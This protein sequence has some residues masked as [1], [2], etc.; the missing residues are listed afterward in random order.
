[1]K[2]N[3]LVNVGW[4]LVIGESWSFRR[5]AADVGLGWKGDLSRKEEKICVESTDM[6]HQTVGRN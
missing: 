1:M 5:M 3:P 4:M 2:Q 6:T